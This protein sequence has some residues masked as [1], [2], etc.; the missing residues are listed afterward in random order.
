GQ[1]LIEPF[2]FGS[3]GAQLVARVG[4]KSGGKPRTFEKAV[5]KPAVPSQFGNSNRC[6]H[7]AVFGIQKRERA[8]A[9]VLAV[10]GYPSRESIVARIGPRRRRQPRLLGQ[11]DQLL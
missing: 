7:V 10:V 2:D 5:P 11:S 8:V 4:R 9:E 6:V 1:P 3:Q